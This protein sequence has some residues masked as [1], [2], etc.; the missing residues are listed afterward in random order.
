MFILFYLTHLAS[1]AAPGSFCQNI[2][3][4]NQIKSFVSCQASTS[5]EACGGLGAQV[6]GRST[7]PA[8]T[9]QYDQ[10]MSEARDLLSHKMASLLHD[11][12]RKSRLIENPSLRLLEIDHEIEHLSQQQTNMRA[13]SISIQSRGSRADI[14]AARHSDYLQDIADLDPH[15]QDVDSERKNL[16]RSR[17]VI[18]QRRDN[19]DPD[20]PLYEPYFL[21]L[22]GRTYDIANT[23]FDNLPQAIQEASR[24]SV[25]SNARKI[26]QRI[27]Q[28]LPLDEPFLDEINSGLTNRWSTLEQRAALKKIA[29]IEEQKVKILFK[30]GSVILD[31]IENQILSHAYSSAIALAKTGG[32]K[33]LLLLGGVV[34]LSIRFASTLLGTNGIGCESQ[35][36]VNLDPNN[37]C[38]P[39]FEINQQI[40]EFLVLTEQE[41]VEVLKNKEICQYYKDLYDHFFSQPQ[42]EQLTCTNDHQFLLNTVDP[43]TQRRLQYKVEMNDQ[44]NITKILTTENG[45]EVRNFKFAGRSEDVTSNLGISNLIVEEYRKLKLFIPDAK[46]C[47]ESKSKECLRDYEGAGL[48]EVGRTTKKE[49]IQ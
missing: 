43:K 1:F 45:L 32:S 24:F 48:S 11:E 3:G 18:R 29:L 15:E 46:F 7:A 33:S 21:P 34:G 40:D 19:A 6:S 22:M 20:Q 9:S 8:L 49:S 17:S 28:G 37:H 41:Q 12:W 39:K 4:L 30:T 10:L 36:Y 26:R 2:K 42:F 5:L 25:S 35:S 14:M 23:D 44:K 16:L 13:L 31:Q 38:A 27:I 47:C